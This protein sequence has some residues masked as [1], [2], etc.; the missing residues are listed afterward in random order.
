MT[1][2]ALFRRVDATIAALR[3]LLAPR[4]PR[5]SGQLGRVA[6]TVIVAVGAP[7]AA[8]L[9][10]VPA[11]DVPTILTDAPSFD[12]V[13][14]KPSAPDVQSPGIRP[15]SNERFTAIGM[16]PRI[17]MQLAYGRDGGLLESQIVSDAK[18]L[19]AERFDIVGTSE[20]LTAGGNPFA[21]VR[22][23]L[24]TVLRERFNARVHT[25]TRTLPIYALVMARSDRRPGPR[26]R[27]PQAPCTELGGKPSEGV[28]ACGFTLAARGQW[29][30]RSLELTVMASNLAHLSDVGRVVRNQ[31]GLRGRFD[32]ELKFGPQTAV[33]TDAA[34]PDPDIFTALQE[35]LGLR[36][37][38]TRGPVEVIV[39][40]Q[41]ERPS[42]N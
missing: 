13:S 22:G 25:E 15:P 40:D 27:P 30:A 9:A 6:A 3:I 1:R 41:I 28:P 12:V 23:L 29:S 26:L 19:D 5:C 42:A 33:G 16:T 14:V 36:L 21:T 32:V 18:W 8:G 37:E 4:T 2:T 39:V 17:L 31:T 10:H 34:N 24:Q 7:M 35:Q 20:E 11:Q 38:S